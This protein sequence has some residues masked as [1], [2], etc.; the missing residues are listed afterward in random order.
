VWQLGGQEACSALPTCGSTTLT[1][2]PF[3]RFGARGGGPVFVHEGYAEE[4][5]AQAVLRPCREAAHMLTSNCSSSPCPPQKEL[6]LCH[7]VPLDLLVLP[8][9]TTVRWGQWAGL[10]RPVAPTGTAALLPVP[11]LCRRAQDLTE[12]CRV[13]PWAKLWGPRHPLPPTGAPPLGQ[14]TDP[15]AAVEPSTWPNGPEDR[16][17]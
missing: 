5:G 12:V 11:P 2:P 3:S 15:T 10:A 9:M 4:Q 17:G 16:S 1:P 14:L 6:S 7:P 8:W 13:I